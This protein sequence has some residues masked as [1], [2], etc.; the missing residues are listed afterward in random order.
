M[1]LEEIIISIFRIVLSLIVF[2]YNFF[3]AILV[4]LIDFADLFLMN[5]LTFGGVRNYQFLDKFLDLFYISYFLIISLRWKLLIRNISIGLFVF[6]IIGFILFE[7]LGDEGVILLD[8]DNKDSLLYT[9]NGAP[10]TYVPDHNINLMF[11]QTTSAADFAVGDFWGALANESRSWFDHLI[12]G[13][14]I[15]HATPTEARLTLEVT[16]A[17][18]ESAKT[19]KP[20]SL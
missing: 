9:D 8:A 10:H 15:P 16:L 3:G 4:I 5:L 12:T 13:N 20:I 14:E 18:E 2:K 1:T 6:R 19:G 17:I 7:V 11:M